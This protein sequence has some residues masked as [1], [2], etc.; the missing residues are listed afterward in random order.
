MATAHDRDPTERVAVWLATASRSVRF[1]LMAQEGDGDTRLR[2][3]S[4]MAA[5]G[6]PHPAV[7][8]EQRSADAVCGHVLGHAVDAGASGGLARALA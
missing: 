6:L 4:V 3:C 1:C 7:G 2:E 5:R 8:D